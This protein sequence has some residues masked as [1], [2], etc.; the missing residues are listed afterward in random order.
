M[1]AILIGLGVT[2][3]SLGIL[4]EYLW[5]TYDAAR[6]NIPFIIDEVEEFDST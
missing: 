2:N 5:R 1:S 4:A 6:Q 3:F